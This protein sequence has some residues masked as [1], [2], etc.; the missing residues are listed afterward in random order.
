MQSRPR[1]ALLALRGLDC[2]LAEAVSL[3]AAESMGTQTE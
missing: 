2:M 1:S 3:E